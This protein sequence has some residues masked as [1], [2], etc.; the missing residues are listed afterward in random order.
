MDRFPE[1]L[2]QTVPHR[3]VTDHARLDH[4]LRPLSRHT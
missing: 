4:P 2:A 1:T 3:E